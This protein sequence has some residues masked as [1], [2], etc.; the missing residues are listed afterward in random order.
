MTGLVRRA[1]HMCAKG[2]TVNKIHIATGLYST[3]NSYL[4]FFRNPLYKG[5]LHYKDLIF[6]NYCE[7]IVEAE[8]WER[9][10]KVLDARA[11]RQHLPTDSETGPHPRRVAS[12]WLL[13]GLV[14]CARCGSPLN[15]HVIKTWDY[16]AC[17]RAK[18]RHDCE[19]K[20]IPSPHLEQAVIEKI[21]AYLR[22]PAALA[23]AQSERMQQYTAATGE[24]PIRRKELDT[25]LANL[26]R[27]ITNLTAAI[28]QHGHSESLLNQLTALEMQEYECK[29][30]LE[31]LT[32]L[33]E[34]KPVDLTPERIGKLSAR[35]EQIMSGGNIEE[36]RALL[37]GWVHRVDAERVGQAIVARVEIYVPPDSGP[38]PPR[39]RGKI[40]VLHRGPPWGH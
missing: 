20:K 10:Q 4:T 30:E 35:F 32:R 3:I 13:S 14:H 19:A 8:I 16:Y 37:A 31:Q 22:D 33:L 15:G 39:R 21:R 6:E 36:K 5:V 28:A 1:F 27:G 29:D 23:A 26:R 25:R 38:D 12:T 40:V 2:E 11:R 7:P 34:A 17:S 9:V 18:R 24:L